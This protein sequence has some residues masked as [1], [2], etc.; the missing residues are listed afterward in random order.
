M[1]SIRY[2]SKHSMIVKK[3]DIEETSICGM[4]IR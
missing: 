3:N 4:A 1:D 2:Y